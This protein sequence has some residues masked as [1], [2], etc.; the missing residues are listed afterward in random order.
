MHRLVTQVQVQPKEKEACDAWVSP[1]T[2]VWCVL[3]QRKPG[4]AFALYWPECVRVRRKFPS[5]PAV[6][7]VAKQTEETTETI[8]PRS[9]SLLV[10]GHEHWQRR[11]AWARVAAEFV[12]K[13][14]ITAA[15]KN[16]PQTRP[17]INAIC[18]SP[19][20]HDNNFSF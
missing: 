17:P 9:Q 8:T 11:V 3:E 10:G 14:M 2:D 12:T 7:P 15:K 4:N 20:K 19:V 5:Q 13:Q 16:R 6:H 1:T 18:N